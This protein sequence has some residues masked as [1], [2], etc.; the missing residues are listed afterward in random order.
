[1]ATV[2]VRDDALGF[3]IDQL[4]KDPLTANVHRLAVLSSHAEAA[5]RAYEADNPHTL[6]ICMRL[7]KTE[8]AAAEIV[9]GRLER[10][11]GV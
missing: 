7:L 9:D 5:V 3:E 6:E 10:S 4:R 2:L 11:L 1:M 8:L